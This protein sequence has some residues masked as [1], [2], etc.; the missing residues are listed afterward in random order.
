MC[1]QY[2][3][4]KY[5]LFLHGLIS[6]INWFSDHYESFNL[7]F[8]YLFTYKYCFFLHGLISDINW[9]SDYCEGVLMCLQYLFYK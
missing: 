4:Y 2:L 6:D 7:Y 3:F 9:F 8:Q 5:Y 1:F